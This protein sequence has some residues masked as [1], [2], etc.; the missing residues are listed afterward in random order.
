M[1]NIIWFIGGCQLVFGTPIYAYM[2]LAVGCLIFC[3]E[4]RE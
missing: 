1:S 2:T 4:K 3:Y